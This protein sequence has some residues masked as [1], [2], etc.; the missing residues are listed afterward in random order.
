[1]SGRWDRGSPGEGKWQTVFEVDGLHGEIYSWDGDQSLWRNNSE[2]RITNHNADS[3][4]CVFTA[5]LVPTKPS[6]YGSW[7]AGVS[8]TIRFCVKPNGKPMLPFDVDENL[9]FQHMKFSAV[10]PTE[11]LDFIP[12][13]RQVSIDAHTPFFL[14]HNLTYRPAEIDHFL[15]YDHMVDLNITHAAFYGCLSNVQL[16]AVG[17]IET[18]VTSAQLRWAARWATRRSQAPWALAPALLRAN[19]SCSCYTIHGPHRA[20]G[21][22]HRRVTPYHGPCAAAREPA[23]VARSSL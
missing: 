8:K 23:R 13:C 21:I 9:S 22:G 20:S 4:H 11:A 12:D 17:N 18:P 14:G 1:V 3:L 19:A 7:P 15:D 6:S 16:N 10:K 2:I 5:F